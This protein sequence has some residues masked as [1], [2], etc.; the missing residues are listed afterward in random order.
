MN[1]KKD[2]VNKE[3]KKTKK[4]NDDVNVTQNGKNSV[5]QSVKHKAVGVVPKTLIKQR[6]VNSV[7]NGANKKVLKSSQMQVKKFRSQNGNNSRGGQSIRIVHLGGLDEIGKNMICFECG[8]DMI[9]VD[10]GMGFP[11]VDMLGVDIVLPD[12][13][14]TLQISSRFSWL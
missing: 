2:G 11:D 5:K 14:I 7:N 13:L 12:P 4:I 6:N 8:K 10:C 3:L 9:I 1:E